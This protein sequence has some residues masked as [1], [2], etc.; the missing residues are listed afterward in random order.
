VLQEFFQSHRKSWDSKLQGRAN[1]F[2]LQE[3]RV[4][5]EFMCKYPSFKSLRD[6][7]LENILQ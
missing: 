5:R 6:K 7:I 1:D 3:N 4:P 2:I